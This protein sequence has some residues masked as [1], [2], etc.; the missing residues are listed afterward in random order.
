MVAPPRPT[1][2]LTPSNSPRSRPEAEV[3]LC[4]AR[5]HLDAIA[6]TALERLCHAGLDWADLISLAARHRLLPLLY[7]HVNAV[8]PLA[9]PRVA[10]VE[11][12]RAHEDTARR[13]KTLA[14]ELLRILRALEANAIPAVAYKGPVLAQALYGDLSLREYGDLDILVRR[15]DILRACAALAPEGY[16]PDYPLTPALEAAFLDSSAQYHRVLV[17][18]DSGASVEL[19]WKTDPDF[20]VE[21]P[22]DSGWWSRMGRTSLEGEAIRTLSAEEQVLM[23]A[24]HVTKHHG[25]RLGWLVDVAELIRQHP[26]LDWDWVVARAEHLWCTR[27]LGVSLQLAGDLIDAPLPERVR[28]R[29]DADTHIRRIADLIASKMFRTDAEGLSSL[30]RLGFEL[31][32]YDDRRH[33]L[34][35]A[36]NVA[37]A[38]SLIEWSSWPLPRPL[39]FLYLPLRLVR[40]AKRYGLRLFGRSGQ[41]A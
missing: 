20:P 12:W 6:R 39:F 32:L 27:R 24:L 37:V 38:P 41:D 18:R 23:C 40:L 31:Q 8:A 36:V 34:R 11:L 3:L 19:H 22:Q 28:Q 7:R 13:N 16:V 25:Y 10:F 29:L 17:H 9:V 35:H 15:D 2:R 14:A 26:R 30:G 21:S 33:Q 4:I 1:A 5:L